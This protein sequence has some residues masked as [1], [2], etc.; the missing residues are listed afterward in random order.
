MNILRLKPDIRE[1]REENALRLAH[2]SDQ[3]PWPLP[4][5]QAFA[6]AST[7]D[8]PSLV[9]SQHMGMCGKVQLENTVSTLVKGAAV[10]QTGLLLYK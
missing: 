1:T 5:L 3:T 7:K 10:H 8:T 2:K 6:I 9:L 4:T